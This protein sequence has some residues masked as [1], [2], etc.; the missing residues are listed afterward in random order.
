[1]ISTNNTSENLT[2]HYLTEVDRYIS[3]LE[4]TLQKIAHELRRIIHEADPMIDERI[5]FGQPWF[6]R[7]G[8]VCYLRGIKSYVALGFQAG[9]FLT[10]PNGVF[11]GTGKSMRHLKVYSME[12]IGRE[13][14]AAWIREAVKLNTSEADEF[15]ELVKS[16]LGGKGDE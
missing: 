8:R 9:R 10:D 1:M 6:I 4:P 2:N 7:N 3:Q 14:I 12:M 5:M 13:Q 11:E 15:A 16:S